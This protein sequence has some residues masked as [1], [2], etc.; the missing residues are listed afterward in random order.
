MKKKFRTCEHVCENNFRKTL[1]MVL[2]S[3]ERKF[4][5]CEHAC[6]NNFCQTLRMVL[7]SY[8]RKFRTCE[9]GYK[10]FLKNKKR[11]GTSLPASFSS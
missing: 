4:R 11:F 9:P 10:A 2:R 7:S 5:T 6:E 1:R 3:Y 8:K